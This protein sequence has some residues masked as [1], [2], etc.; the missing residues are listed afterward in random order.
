MASLLNLEHPTVREGSPPTN[1]EREAL[2][3]RF[4][5]TPISALFFSS[6]NVDALHEAIRYGVFVQTNQQEVVGRQSDGELLI[7]MRSVYLL[8]LADAERRSIN[9]PDPP[10]EAVRYL[11]GAVL[12]YAVPMVLKEIAAYKKY[13]A[14]VDKVPVPLEHPTSASSAGLRN[15]N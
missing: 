11:N 8:E 13:A 12:D 4:D 6:A 3:G 14:E 2:A 5:S 10:L 1:Y 15:V 9:T 7:I